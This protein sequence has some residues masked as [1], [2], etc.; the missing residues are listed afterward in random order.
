MQSW[1]RSKIYVESTFCFLE[2]LIVICNL[3]YGFINTLGILHVTLAKEMHWFLQVIVIFLF[4]SW[5]ELSYWM[6]WSHCFILEF[7]T[8]RRSWSILKL[9][10]S[11]SIISLLYEEMILLMLQ[12]YY[13][14]FLEYAKA[15]FTQAVTTNKKYQRVKWY[16][17]T[18]H[19]ED[20]W[21]TLTYK[22]SEVTAIKPWLDGGSTVNS[23]FLFRNIE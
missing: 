6:V 19:I 9:A 15:H 23:L 18:K 20:P 17:C 22:K 14:Y 16:Y 21:S 10:G 13:L 11:N 7:I 4:S 3:L 2:A 8:R 1:V 5:K 12:D